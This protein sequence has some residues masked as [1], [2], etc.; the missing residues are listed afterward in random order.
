MSVWSTAR[1]AG[2]G[3]EPST[4]KAAPLSDNGPARERRDVAGVAVCRRP[5]RP[6]SRGRSRVAAQNRWWLAA[7]GGEDK[8][9]SGVVTTTSCA[10]VA[11]T[12]KAR[13]VTNVRET[14]TESSGSL[15][16]DNRRWTGGLCA[17]SIVT[18]LVCRRG[19]DLPPSAVVKGRYKSR[20][21]TS[22]WRDNNSNRPSFLRL[23]LTAANSVTAGHTVACRGS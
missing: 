10:V 22:S 11:V 21:S 7:R 20:C 4:S 17:S 14:V 9:R 15:R 13:L 16:H 3:V 23:N 19:G 18:P 2:G 6:K 1:S 12:H 5:P 8:A